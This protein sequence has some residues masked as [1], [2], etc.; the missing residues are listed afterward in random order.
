MVKYELVKHG[1]T[2]TSVERLFGTI[3]AFSRDTFFLHIFVYIEIKIIFTSYSAVDSVVYYRSLKVR[4]PQFN[5][6]GHSYYNNF[7]ISSIKWNK[8]LS[9]ISAIYVF[10]NFSIQQFWFEFYKFLLN[11]KSTIVIIFKKKKKTRNFNSKQKR[12]M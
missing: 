1:D 7:P 8:K 2:W 3:D 4:K 5:N 6:T 11:W 10:I 9:S 12:L